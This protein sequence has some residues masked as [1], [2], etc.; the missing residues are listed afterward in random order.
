VRLLAATVAE[1]V[2][3]ADV[4]GRPALQVGQTRP[5]PPYVVPSRENNPWFWLIGSS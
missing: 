4:D 5:S 3:V 2:R 1:R